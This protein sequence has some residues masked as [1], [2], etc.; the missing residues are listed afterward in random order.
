MA[1]TY[2]PLLDW[3]VK[4]DLD[5]A[6][7]TPDGL[8]VVLEPYYSSFR[9][10]LL[11]GL[12]DLTGGHPFKQILLHI[13]NRN[14]RLIFM[15]A[16]LQS[17][18]LQ[19]ARI[20]VLCET[21]A[22]LER[23]VP[24]AENLQERGR[25]RFVLCTMAEALSS[26]PYDAVIVLE[27]PLNVDPQPYPW[28]GLAKQDA[29]L[30]FGR[31]DIPRPIVKSECGG[32]DRLDVN[33]SVLQSVQPPDSKNDLTHII[34]HEVDPKHRDIFAYYCVKTRFAMSRA[35]PTLEEMYGALDKPANTKMLR[36]AEFRYVVFSPTVIYPYNYTFLYGNRK[37][38]KDS[39]LSYAKARR[40]DSSFRAALHALQMWNA[41]ATDDME[42]GEEGILSSSFSLSLME[43][44][45]RGTLPVPDNLTRSVFPRAFD[46]KR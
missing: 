33:L 15:A 39:F 4:N 37:T 46:R 40:P 6:P 9:V 38:T 19:S 44:F 27:D 25:L 1:N 28:L 7:F 21:Q 17:P 16:T 45:I 20:T 3:L 8:A 41:R 34:T 43:S 12:L 2:Q 42:E 11:L 24:E 36:Q 30:F 10:A 35:T 22:D 14:L 32:W 5:Y 26:D 29:Y 31:T 18:R 23:M 13:R